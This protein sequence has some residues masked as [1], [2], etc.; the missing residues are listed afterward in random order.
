MRKHVHSCVPGSGFW[1]LAG[2]W[3]LL[4]DGSNQRPDLLE[5]LLHGLE[6]DRGGPAPA[7]ATEAS[8]AALGDRKLLL[9]VGAAPERESEDFR[10]LTG[11]LGDVGLAGDELGVTAGGGSGEDAADRAGELEEGADADGLHF[12]CL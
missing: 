5:Q 4:T 7:E 3:V 10:G 2:G 8:E 12:V 9:V 6:V 11:D 1:A